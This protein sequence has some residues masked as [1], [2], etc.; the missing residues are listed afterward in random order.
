MKHVALF[1]LVLT[2]SCAMFRSVARTAND[3]A[4]EA[5]EIF[6]AKQPETLGMSVEDFCAIQRNVDPFLD[7]ILS[8]Q[9]LSAAKLS[10]AKE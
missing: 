10:A 9:K 6:G 3:V 5:C 1:L 2:T 4:R 8:A 7:A